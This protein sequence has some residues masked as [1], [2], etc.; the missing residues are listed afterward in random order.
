MKT[1]FMFL[2]T[3]ALKYPVPF[4]N[5]LN[6]QYS[7][8]SNAYHIIW[9]VMYVY[10]SDRMCFRSKNIFLSTLL[11]IVLSVWNKRRGHKKNM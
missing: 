4:I 9:N 3:S 10:I 8:L 11:L 6:V 2:N 7:G 5:V 1:I